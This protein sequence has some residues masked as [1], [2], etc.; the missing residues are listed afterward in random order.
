MR[1]TALLAQFQ[2]SRSIQENLSAIQSVLEK[3]NPGDILVFPEGALS[4][5]SHE[6][7]FLKTIDRNEL[8]NTI[9]FLSSEAQRKDTHMWVGSYV[10]EGEQ[11]YNIALGFTPNGRIHRYRKINLAEHERSTISPGDDLPV[12]KLSTPEGELKIGVQICR[13]IRFPEQWG[14]LARKGAQVIIHINNAT[15][16]VMH[17]Q[18]WRSH[19]IS[20]AASFQRFVISV[21]NAGPAQLCPTIAI[22]PSGCVIEEILSERTAVTRVDLDLSQV[23]DWY[24]DQGRRD[25][26]QIC[27]PEAKDRRK[28]ARSMKIESLRNDLD[29]LV[30][31]K[32]LFS[33]ER[34]SARTEA[35]GL[36]KIIED[37]HRLRSKDRV[38]YDL[39]T[40]AEKLRQELE[41]VN[42][43]VFTNFREDLQ[44]GKINKEK[45][46]R[47]LNLYTD[48]RSENP[49]QPHYGY[50]DLDGFI[51]GIYQ[52]KP[53]PVEQ[54]ELAPGMVRYQPTPSSVILELVDQ[55]NFTPDDI[56]VDLGS[57]L[58]MVIFLVNKLAGTRCLGIEYQP[59]LCNFAVRMADELNLNNVN[60]INADVQDISFA[61]GSVFFMFNPFGGRIF[62]TVMKKLMGEAKK[63]KITVSSYG[64]GTDPIS[65]QSWLSVVEPDTLDDFKLAIFRSDITD[66]AIAQNY[67]NKSQAS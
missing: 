8:N 52:S 15:R 12:F 7:V 59:A 62:D 50:E 54:I 66:H 1:I 4:G 34:F 17:Q 61:E 42:T 43:S 3:S 40:K 57:G 65:N 48:Y 31:N 63:R 67:S 28:V 13:E 18:V 41:A 44:S 24:L 20:H 6:P 47:T 51:K 46:R 2:V 33:E 22:S 38:V 58:G 64:V 32:D 56:F 19:L 5:Y 29:N 49:H 10:H 53:A 21:N 14:W 37:L 36:I 23:S 30:E 25:V 60:F 9:N 45:F 35:F 27:K 16:A 26:V 39:Y 11:W 55:V